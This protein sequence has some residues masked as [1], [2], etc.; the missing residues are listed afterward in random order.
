MIIGRSHY[1]VFHHIHKYNYRSYCGR[2]IHCLSPSTGKEELCKYCVKHYG[3]AL[4]AKCGERYKVVRFPY[5]NRLKRYEILSY[6]ESCFQQACID[7]TIN[8]YK[9]KHN[10]N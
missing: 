4:C 5:D 9:E 10:E 3:Y 1:G 2:V 8:F 6:C 7:F